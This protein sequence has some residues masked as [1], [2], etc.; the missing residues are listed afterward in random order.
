MMSASYHFAQ[1]LHGPG[2]DQPTPDGATFARAALLTW[3]HKIQ[4]IYP[5]RTAPPLV[6]PHQ[7]VIR[8]AT[9]AAQKPAL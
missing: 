8:F 3:P 9:Q 1:D 4:F 7:R 5:E 2:P 6:P